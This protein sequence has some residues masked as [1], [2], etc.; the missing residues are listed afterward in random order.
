MAVP[1]RRR[2]HAK[3]GMVRQ[4]TALKTPN[5]VTCSNCGAEIKPHHVCPACGFY[6]G[7]QVKAVKEA[8]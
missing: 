1:T 8:E 5:T 4:N 3:Q 6:K 2:G 7:K